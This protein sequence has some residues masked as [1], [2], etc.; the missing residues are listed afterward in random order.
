M[1]VRLMFSLSLILNIESRSIYFVLE[2]PQAELDEDVYTEPPFGFN[3]DGQHTR[4]LKFNK[5]LYVLKKI[6]SNWFHF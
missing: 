3:F 6:S 4:V 1:S 2:F 5:S